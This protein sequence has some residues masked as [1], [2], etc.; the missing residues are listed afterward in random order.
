MKKRTLKEEEAA[1]VREIQLRRR[2][3]RGIVAGYI[4][5]IS[6]RHNTSPRD[7]AARPEVALAAAGS[8]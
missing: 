4:H 3:K 6:A 1:A 7:G 8:R 2:V 5:E